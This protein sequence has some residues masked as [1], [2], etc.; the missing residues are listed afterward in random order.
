MVIAGWWYSQEMI[1]ALLGKNTSPLDQS[2]VEMIG[3]ELDALKNQMESH[4]SGVDR[5]IWEQVEQGQ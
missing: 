1:S 2:A 4:P 5:E 3:S